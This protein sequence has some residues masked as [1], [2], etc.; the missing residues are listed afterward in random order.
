MPPTSGLGI[1]MDR[2]LMFLTN[3]PSIQEVLFFPQMKPE[4]FAHTK[5]P[6]FTEG[7]K[8]IFEIIS[9]ENSMDL[10]ELKREANLSNKQWDKAL[11]GLVKDGH[12]KVTK[13]EDY[14]VVD[15]IG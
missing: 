9:K 6:E 14:L 12:V 1:G 10:N 3:N 2:L 5:E 8:I 7:E 4:S 11:K 15:L 13:T